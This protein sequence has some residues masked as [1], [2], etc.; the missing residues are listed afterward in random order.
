[1][2]HTAGG[3]G[4]MEPHKQYQDCYRLMMKLKDNAI[5]HHRIEKAG[6]RAPVAWLELPVERSMVW[7]SQDQWRSAP[8]AVES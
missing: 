2:S 8:W 7:F 4:E 5:L 6:P 3:A 1:M